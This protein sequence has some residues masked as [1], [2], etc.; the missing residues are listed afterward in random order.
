MTIET[1]N[2]SATIARLK[3]TDSDNGTVDCITVRS[4][5]SDDEGQSSDGE[6][7]VEVIE[8]VTN[9]ILKCVGKVVKKKPDRIHKKD[10]DECCGISSLQGPCSSCPNQRE[11]SQFIQTELG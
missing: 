1:P 2:E 7:K 11:T 6:I 9:E 10:G 3:D 4:D 8:E 5:K